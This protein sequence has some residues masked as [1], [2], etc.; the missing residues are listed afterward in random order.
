MTSI[1]TRLNAALAPTSRLRILN[2]FDPVI[3][4]RNRL[5]RLFGF[6]YRI[7]IF[8]PAEKRQWGYYVY[9]L[10]EGDRFVGRIEV[11]SDREKGELSV[12]QLWSEP[13]VKWTD[14]RQAKLEAELDRMARF[15]GATDIVWLNL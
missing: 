14:A 13:G 15:V 4:D 12:H 2:P 5:T 6:D 9:P 1:E 3:R 8:V 7:E 10:L 11:K